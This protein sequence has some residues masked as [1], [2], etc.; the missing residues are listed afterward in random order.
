MFFE[1]WLAMAREGD[2]RIFTNWNQVRQSH[3]NASFAG[4]RTG[5]LSSNPN[6]QNVPKVFEDKDDGYEHPAFLAE[7]FFRFGLPPLP[8]MRRYMLPDKEGVWGHRDFNQQELRVLAHFEDGLLAKR[9]NDEPR[10]D[11]HTSVQTALC[12][13]FG[14]TLS[15]GGTKI[16]NFSDVYG[17]GLVNLAE[18]L[19][20]SVETV[21]LIRAG[22]NALMPGVTELTNSVKLRG[23]SGKA[24]RTWGGREY[25][26]EAPSFSKKFGRPMTFEYKLLNYLIQG[27]SAD[28]T[29][30]AVIRYA[31]HPKRQA[32]FL[33]TV[34]DEL[35]A[36]FPKG[37]V[38]EEM[39]ILQEVMET[40]ELGVPLLSDGKTGPNWA[41]IKK[42]KD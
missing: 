15:R 19:K 23:A 38:K 37:Q 35:N 13:Q 17:K 2:G 7:V 9:Y 39:K 24:I 11:I 6:L 41:D 26:T 22:K 40:I 8:L 4:A 27:S 29:K 5:R 18:S 20:V 21:K 10:F 14:I 32:R 1:S 28:L 25:F 31:E 33:L 34:H 42:W 3:G 16:V 30:E 12:E 36:S